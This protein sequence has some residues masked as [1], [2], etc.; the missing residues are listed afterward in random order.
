M[1]DRAMSTTTSPTE[2]LAERLFDSCLGAMEVATVFL[3]DRLGLYRTLDERGPSTSGELA[4]ACSLHERYV[5]EWLEQQAAAALLE[6]D[7]A[8]AAPGER[9]V[10]LAPGHREVLVDE[11]SLAY[12]APLGR[13]AASTARALPQL[14][15]AFRTGG[16]VPWAAYGADGREGQA[17]MNRPQF[18]NL[19]TNVWL[20]ALPDVQARLQSGPAHVADLCCG[21]G[22]SSIAFALGYPEV[23]IDGFDLDE[24]SIAA[25]RDHAAAAGVEDRVR[26]QAR[27]AAEGDLDGAYD[28]VTIF[29][30]VHDVARPVELLASARRLAGPDGAVLVMDERVAESFTA[31][32]D[33]IE[34]FM[35]GASVLLCLPAG[36]AEQPSAA[37]G[38]AMRAT[39]LR[40][41]AEQAGFAGVEV[42][43]ID[44]DFWRFYRLTS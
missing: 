26:F 7:D 16:G 43:P 33:P 28:L 22:W 34:R 15:D 9:R 25:A 2:A 10:G 14:M 31:P 44:H 27:D 24:P 11:D 36:M 40:D 23:T 12:V 6:V 38:T 42:L 18:L 39:T 19:L 41:Y 8:A 4:A 1:Q 35:Y 17:A 21:E 3:G 20:P 30:A 13:I 5:R 29:E 32:G 37:T